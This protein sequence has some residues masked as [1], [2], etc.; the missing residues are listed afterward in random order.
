MRKS[1][2]IYFVALVAVSCASGSGTQSNPLTNLTNPT[3]EFAPLDQQEFGTGTE[4]AL[5]TG[6]PQPDWDEPELDNQ[7]DR[8]PPA[9]QDPLGAEND[10]AEV[11]AGAQVPVTRLLSDDPAQ[12]RIRS[13]FII[14]F[15]ETQLLAQPGYEVDFELQRAQPC[16]RGLSSCV[17]SVAECDLA[18]DLTLT[19]SYISRRGNSMLS[20]EDDPFFVRAYS[21]NNGATIAH[22]PALSM[23]TLE[24]VS[25]PI[26]E[27]QPD[28]HTPEQEEVV[29]EV[30]PGRSLPVGSG[31]PVTAEGISDDEAR[32]E[33]QGGGTPAPI[34]EY[35]P[36]IA[37]GSG[38][39][40]VYARD[41]QNKLIERCR[42]PH[43]G[44]WSYQQINVTIS[45]DP[46]PLFD[47]ISG[48]VRV[49]VF[50]EANAN[51]QRPL[52]QLIKYTNGDNSLWEMPTVIAR[53]QYADSPTVFSSSRGY[54]LIF[55]KEGVTEET[56][57]HL[58]GY[59][60]QF[61]EDNVSNV[62]RIPN[63]GSHPAI[64]EN[65][66]TGQIQLFARNVLRDNRGFLM[67]YLSND[68]LNYDEPVRIGECD[69]AYHPLALRLPSNKT[70][71][72]ARCTSTN[73]HREQRGIFRY[74]LADHQ[75]NVET[76]VYTTGRDQPVLNGLTAHEVRLQI[77]PSEMEEQWSD[78]QLLHDTKKYPDRVLLIGFNNMN[79]VRVF[80]DP[81]NPNPAGGMDRLVLDIL[82][83]QTMGHF[84]DPM[85]GTF[86]IL[87]HVEEIN[88]IWGQSPLPAR[89]V[90]YGNY[91]SHSTELANGLTEPAGNLIPFFHG[92]APLYPAE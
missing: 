90:R 16:T 85:T 15:I 5:P 9:P 23:N 31:G 18:A 64:V 53:G 89:W 70:F 49:F 76:F 2:I 28:A 67:R 56:P 60:V 40:C 35:D 22:S 79:F 8:Q 82:K 20:H 45:G 80:G 44:A 42:R 73:P 46:K 29:V 14:G 33:G 12:Y 78:Y 86:E 36:R 52:L 55:L 91:E 37:M 48:D 68:G 7:H 57:G 63:I 58:L 39:M 10:D 54:A 11:A 47:P 69:Q 81:I 59:R 43:D 6:Q 50:G 62:I 13:A 30:E 34:A 72:Y 24:S 51:N 3:P 26:R 66:E 27:R 61:G 17:D 21:R 65:P 38:N 32:P 1:W 4:I 77:G 74:R 87:G 41:Q 88:N 19:C 92:H 71:V 84:I 25:F 75:E 83:L